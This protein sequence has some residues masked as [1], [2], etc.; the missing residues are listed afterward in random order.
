MK[1]GKKTP[2][3][4]CS[5]LTSLMVELSEDALLLIVLR[6]YDLYINEQ[7]GT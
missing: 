3:H 4:Y 7:K 2:G 6:D 5:F 1:K